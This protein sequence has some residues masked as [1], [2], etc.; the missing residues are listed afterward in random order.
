MKK[1][2]NVFLSISFLLPLSFKF[3]ASAH[4]KDKIEDL[5]KDCESL[6]LLREDSIDK[7][8]LPSLVLASSID[9]PSRTKGKSIEIAGECGD[10]QETILVLV[11]RKGRDSGKSILSYNKDLQLI[12]QLNI[13]DDEDD[14]DDK[15]DDEE[16]E[17]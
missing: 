7:H 11:K 16:E 10:S 2:F 17:D 8:T 9:L 15:D 4:S 1:I 14:K 13:E 5:A 3:Y 6:Y 12:G